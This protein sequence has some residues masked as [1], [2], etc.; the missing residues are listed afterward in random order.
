MLVALLGRYGFW[1]FYCF[2][3]VEGQG[4]ITAVNDNMVTIADVSFD[5]FKGQR[6]DDA[7]LQDA[8]EG[9]RSVDGIVTFVDQ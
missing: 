2:D 7:A 8:F 3:Y 5:E 9:P 1:F 6:V 4:L